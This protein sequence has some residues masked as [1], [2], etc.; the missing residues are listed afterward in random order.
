MITVVQIIISIVLIAA[1]MLQSRGDS[2]T[3]GLAGGQGQSY[4]SKKGL[5]RLLFYL[6]IVVAVLFASISIFAIIL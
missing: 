6:T 3:G 4:R 2:G 1:I 5:E